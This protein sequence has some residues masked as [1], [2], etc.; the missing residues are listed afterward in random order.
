MTTQAGGDMATVQ[1]IE[2]YLRSARELREHQRDLICGLMDHLGVD[3]D[4]FV[5]DFVRKAIVDGTF[6]A[7]FIAELTG[8]L[9][10]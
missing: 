8:K 9:R 4:V 10:R 5:A 7:E 1:S 2:A 6:S 3:T